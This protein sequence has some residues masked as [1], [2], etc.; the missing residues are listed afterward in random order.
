MNAIL[1]FDMPESC[2]ECPLMY[3]Q[4]IGQKPYQQIYNNCC[5]NFNPGKLGG[6]VTGKN[7]RAPFCPLKIVDDKYELTTKP[8][9]DACCGG[10]MFWFD[11]NNPMVEFC[12]KRVVSKMIVGKDRNARAFECNPDTVADFKNLPFPDESFYLVV[13]DP[14]HLKSAG[15]EKSYMAIKYGILPH[16]WKTEIRDGFWEC[17]RVLRENGV[18]IFKWNETQ[19]RVSEIKT[20]I[21]ADPLFGHISGKKQNTHWLC[22]MKMANPA[23][24]QP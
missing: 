23:Q 6:S 4:I 13:F 18:L 15:K 16:E 9:L 12:D 5:F 21:G 10:R 1:E 17:M 14:P 22:F 19:I 8:I 2:S 7:K 20:A 3:E 11:K 24:T